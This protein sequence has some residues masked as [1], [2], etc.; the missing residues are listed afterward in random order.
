[1]DSGNSKNECLAKQSAPGTDAIRYAIDSNVLQVKPDF[2]ER[3]QLISL[4][5]ACLDPG[6][7][8]AIALA[9]KNSALLLIDEK[10][11]RNTAE[12]MGLSITG[13]L[14]VLVKAKKAGQLNNVRAAIEK[15]QLNGYRYSEKLVERVILL[16][17]E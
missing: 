3:D 15:L 17:G 8:Q 4:L 9:K 1:M 12:Q 10:M 7:A 13:S 5:S 14:A 6:E 2:P 11:G 16:A